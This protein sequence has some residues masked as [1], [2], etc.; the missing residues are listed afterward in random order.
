MKMPQILHILEKSKFLKH[1][2]RLIDQLLQQK[3]TNKTKQTK[4]KQKKK[5]KKQE[6]NKQTKNITKL[7]NRFPP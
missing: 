7:S 3:Q 1:N 2:W 6:T 4:N 5:K